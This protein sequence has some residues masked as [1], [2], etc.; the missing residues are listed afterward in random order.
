MT[1]TCD[2]LVRSQTLYPTELRA[3][4]FKDVQKTRGCQSI[5]LWDLRRATHETKPNT[6]M[7]R[8]ADFSKTALVRAGLVNH[9]IRGIDAI[10]Y[11]FSRHAFLN[12]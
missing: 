1:R 4:I 2:L 9:N 8:F 11:L 5:W 7:D 10:L 12:H 3:L 6:R